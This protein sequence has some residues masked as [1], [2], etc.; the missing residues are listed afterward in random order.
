MKEFTSRDVNVFLSSKM[1]S[2]CPWCGNQ[3]WELLTDS[4]E[5][6]QT[7][8]V[9]A[10]IVRVSSGYAVEWEQRKPPMPRIHMRCKECGCLI[11][12]DFTFIASKLLSDAEVR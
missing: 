11:D 9:G 8:Q 1:H 2:S 10:R 5:E 6:L 4:G 3:S 7:S 12:F